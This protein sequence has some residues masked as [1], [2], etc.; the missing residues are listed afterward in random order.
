[1]MVVDERMQS[2]AGLR[3]K[4]KILGENEQKSRIDISFMW[5]IRV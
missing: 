4:D 5:F 2:L 3:L 1:M